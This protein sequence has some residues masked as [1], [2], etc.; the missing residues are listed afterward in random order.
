[1][2]SDF[3]PS[4]GRWLGAFAALSVLSWS[5]AFAAVIEGQVSGGGAPIAKSTVTLWSASG[6]APQQL[7]EAKT[8]DDGRFTI[9]FQTQSAEGISYLI[10]K[11]GEPA[12]RRGGDNPAIALLSVIGSK[13]PE[14]VTVNEFT[15]V[16]S[17]WTNN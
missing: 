12:A 13:P 17:V 8:A 9:S 10:A 14:R 5:P 16:A 1:L 4:A 15:T 2:K 11:G 3:F 7:G 6:D